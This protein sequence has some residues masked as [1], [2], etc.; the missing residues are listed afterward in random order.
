MRSN[1]SFPSAEKRSLSTKSV[2]RDK[3]SP[4]VFYSPEEKQEKNGKTANN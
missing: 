2:R 3:S 1:A 4:D